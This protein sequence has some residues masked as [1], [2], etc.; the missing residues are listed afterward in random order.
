[1][2]QASNLLA[3]ALDQYRIP[4]AT[5]NNDKEDDYI[6]ASIT[7]GDMEWRFIIRDRL[8]LLKEG[9]VD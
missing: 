2:G 6:V 9:S 1:M 8:R 5:S 3:V 4:G 7:A